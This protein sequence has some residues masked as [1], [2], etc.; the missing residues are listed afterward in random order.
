MHLRRKDNERSQPSCESLRQVLVSQGKPDRCLCCDRYGEPAYPGMSRNSS[1]PTATE[2]EPCR[3]KEMDVQMSALRSAPRH[4]IRVARNFPF[5]LGRLDQNSLKQ[6]ARLCG[7]VRHAIGCEL[8][9]FRDFRRINNATPTPSATA[10]AIP[11]PKAY[12]DGLDDGT[13]RIRT[14]GANPMRSEPRGSR[15]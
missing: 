12:S 6:D 8:Y 13:I 2:Q 7:W 9:R 14:R 15:N 11:A 5:S 4:R 10:I 1:L 3:V